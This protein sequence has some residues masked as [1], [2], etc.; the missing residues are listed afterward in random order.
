MKVRIKF[1]K[2]GVLKY[3]G[4][5]DL[6]RYFQKAFR[7]TDIDVLYSK[8]FSPHMI[9]SFAQPLGVGAES[10][11]EYFDVEVADDENVST[12][13]ERLNA[14]MAE[15]VEIQDA[16]ILPEKTINAM[17]SVAA[18]AYEINFYKKSPLSS[19]LMEKYN[20]TDNVEFIKVTKTGEHPINVKDFVFEIYLKDEATLFAI[21]DCSSSGNL[22]PSTLVTSLLSL[23]N[24]DI[25]EY[26]YHVTRKETYKRTAENKLV[27]LNFIDEE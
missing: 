3:I 15:G 11:G 10:D 2:H 4:H 14:E 22:K 1:S 27:P 9:M 12:I 13:A 5:L 26:P 8:G 21:V 16:I 25:N 7:R 24:M 17:A 19:N 20:S 18:A 23:D 6:M